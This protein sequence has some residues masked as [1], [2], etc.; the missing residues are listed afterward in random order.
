MSGKKR[1]AEVLDVS[2]TEDVS[3]S[4]KDAKIS[5]WHIK[6]GRWMQKVASSVGSD[7]KG[8]CIGYIMTNQSGCGQYEWLRLERWPRSTTSNDWNAF[9][10]TG[11][12]TNMSFRVHEG[13]DTCYFHGSH[14]FDPYH[15]FRGE[16]VVNPNG[17]IYCSAFA[18]DQRAAELTTPRE[19][20]ITTVSEHL[21]TT[22]DLGRIVVCYIES[23]ENAWSV[24]DELYK[25]KLIPFRSS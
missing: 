3:D 12:F 10:L 18:D 14:V 20:L 16:D 21:G 25:R 9:P 8:L 15:Y 19:T 22:T 24:F 5:S 2:E 4:H 13:M 17:V 23:S 11:R 6:A 7:N 1:K